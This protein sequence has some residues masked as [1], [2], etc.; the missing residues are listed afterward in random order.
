[1]FVEIKNTLEYIQ[2][3]DL[4]NG[5]K[6][7]DNKKYYIMTKNINHSLWFEVYEHN[8]EYLVFDGNY[9]YS[10]QSLKDCLDYCNIMYY[11]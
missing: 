8:D 6:V 5:Y 3:Y 9:S 4:E 7:I 10:S 2:D 1:M 11:N